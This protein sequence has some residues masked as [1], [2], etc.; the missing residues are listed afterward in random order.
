MQ[1]SAGKKEDGHLE[2][3]HK[4][5]VGCFIF[6]LATFFGGSHDIGLHSFLFLLRIPV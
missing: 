1:R 4:F 2:A 3:S 6:K 5:F